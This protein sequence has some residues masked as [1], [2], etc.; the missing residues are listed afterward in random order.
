M[1]FS[2]MTIRVRAPI[3]RALRSG[4]ARFGAEER[5]LSDED[6]R[7]VPEELRDDLARFVE[8]YDSWDGQYG[9][10]LAVELDVPDDSIESIVAALRRERSEALAAAH[11]AKLKEWL[12]KPDAAW[13]DE[14][15]PWNPDNDD[16]FAE[17]TVY[18]VR[19][20]YELRDDPAIAARI[21]QVT[22]LAR[23]EHQKLEAARAGLK[24][25]AL[26]LPQ[27]QRAAEE[28]Y[29]VVDVAVDALAAAI[30]SRDEDA[31]VFRTDREE[32]KRS[33]LQERKA[34]DAYAFQ[35]L[36]TVQEHIRSLVLPEGVDVTVGRVQRLKLATREGNK[37]MLS[38][39]ATVVPV[40]ITPHVTAKRVVLFFADA[41]EKPGSLSTDDIP[42]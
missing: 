5:S 18:V 20:V 41:E 12:D 37:W 34:P 1:G 29:D 26:R 23:G 9:E 40:W 30:A 42:F 31:F 35:V 16:F 27:Y 21:E 32:F 6:V 15:G 36:D 33:Q 17:G 13:I 7:A 14:Y 22:R 10:P 19:E 2:E 3:R 4:F 24:E 8:S 39:P 38:V 28:G 25:Y 11:A